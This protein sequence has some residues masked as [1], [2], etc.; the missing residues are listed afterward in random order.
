MYRLATETGERAADFGPFHRGERAVQERVGVADRVARAGAAI[1]DYMPEQHR[2]FF[3][4][5]S[6]L[7]LAVVD[8][9][10]SPIATIL[11]GPRGFVA[12]C[13]ER[14]LHIARLPDANDPVRDSLVK[15]AAAGVLGI[16]LGTR[17]RNRAN[18]RIADVGHDGFTIAVEQSFGNCPQY[19]QARELEVDAGSVGRQAGAT[20]SLAGLDDEAARLIAAA[21]TLFVASCAEGGADM[22][23][24]GG[25]PG[26]VRVDGD[27]LT[28]PDFA[29]NRYFNTLGNFLI[30]PKASL[31]FI[32]F[33]KGDLLQVTGL[34]EIVWAGD[35]VERF[36]RAERLWRVRV[37]RA[38]RC[39][40][41][42]PEGWRS[43]GF[44]PTTERTGSW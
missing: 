4:S 40:G 24:R 2:S 20:E 44:A 36:A 8:R 41:V 38:W 32:D 21:D 10:G 19:I 35:E 31:L 3:A 23:H 13:D 27:V 37:T 1:R 39:R 7:P 25:R 22:S 9:S 14:S 5:L 12:A 16:E 28:V 29:G 30:S 6:Y 43:R 18:G 42:L 15:G 33:A 17:R 26:F 34:V 11:T